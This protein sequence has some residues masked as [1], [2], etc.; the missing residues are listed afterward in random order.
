MAPPSRKFQPKSIRNPS[1]KDAIS[2]GN[3]RS[4]TLQS[5]KLPLQLEDDVPDFPRGGR[6]SFRKEEKDKIG[7][8]LDNDI[9]ADHRSLEKRKKGK[10]VQKKNQSEEDDL[11][12]LFG[13]GIKGK[14]PRYSNRIT[15]KNV[16]P[17]MKLWGVIAEV[18]EKDIVVSLPGGLRG[19]IRACEAF[20]PILGGEV[21]QDAQ[22]NFLSSVYAGQLVSCIVMQ[23][24][25]DKKEVVNRKIWLSLHLS[26][27]HKGL[28]LDIIQEGMV[29]SAYVKSIEDHGF[30]LHF[31]C[32][33][34]TGFMSKHSKSEKGSSEVRVGQILQGVVRSVDRARKVVHIDS[35]PDVVSKYVTKELK[36]VSLDLLIPGMMVDARVVSTL[37]NGIMLSFLTYFTGT[38]DVFNLDKTFPSP[39]WKDDYSKNMRINARILFIDP[40]TRAVGLT[41]NPYLVGNNA[42]PS[43]VK[44][45]DIFDQ[46]KVIRVD[47][48]S[49]LLL[50]TPTLP[51]PTPTYVN[52]TDVAD[53]DV[54]K[55]EKSFKEGSLVR[56]RVLGFRRLEGLATGILKTSAFEGSVFT[57]SDVKPGMVVKAK[58]IAV[59]SF[60]AIVQISSGVKALCPLRHMSEL[61]IQK[62]RK[63][64]QV[65]VE[66]VFRVL[67]CKSKRITVTHKKTLVKSK[68][69]ILSSY[70]DATNGLVTHGW[71]TKIENHG[72]FVRFYNGVQGF[73]PRYELCLDPGSDIDSMYHVEQVVKCR[74]V[75]CIPAS[76]RM[77]LSFN[78]SLTRAV[79]VESV[80][81]GSLVA[82]VVEK[83]S[84]HE[85]VVDVNASSHMKGTISLEHLAD[86]HGLAI[87]MVSA[88]KPGYQ[89]D[90]LLVLDIEGNNLVLT[91]KYSLINSAQELPVDVTQIRCHST[92]PGY[93][94]NIIESGCFV[95][96]IGHLTGFA[97]K[98]KATD[99]WRTD[100]S[101]VFFV[102]QSVRSNI[103][104]VGSE[105]GRI[106]LS[107]KQ[108]LCCSTDSSFIQEY[109]LMEE[110]IA[111]LQL[112]DSEGLALSWISAFDIGSI[113][114]GKV[115]ETKD[116]GVIISFKKYND[117]Y[118]FI[119]H[120][121]L[122]GIT[123]ENNSTVRALVID[124]SKIERLV[125]L[126]LKPEFLKSPKE[127]SSISKTVKKRKSREYNKLELNQV[128]DALVEIVKETYL[129][130]SIPSHNFAIGY[131]SITDYNN[132]KLPPKQYTNG[133]SVTA[134]VVALPNPT[135]CGRLLLLLKTL[136]DGTES[137]SSKRAK[138]KSSYD[139][140]SLVQVEITE[141]KPLELR[142]KFG[143]GFHGRI[144]VTEAADNNSSENPFSDYRIGQTLLARIVSK[145]SMPYSSKGSYPW[146]FSIKPSILKGSSDM[147]GLIPAEDFNYSCGQYVSGYVYKIDH[148]WAWLTVSRKVKARLHILD[149]SCEPSELAKFRERFFV[150]K[151]LSG[152][153]ISINEEKKLLHV[154]LSPLAVGFGEL[155]ENDPYCH[156]KFHIIE[157]T[158]VGGRISKVIPG[159][160]GLLVQIDQHLYGKVH[161]T[162]LTDAWVS[163]PLSGYREGQFVKCKVLEINRTGNGTFHIDLSLR[164]TSN[165]RR[166][167][168]LTEHSSGMPSS[169][170]HVDKL[171]DLRP[172]MVVQG[173]VKNISAK[174]CFV[175]LSRKIDA[176]V[177]L[178]NLSVN[179]VDNPEKDF[180][181]GKLVSGRVLSVEP[182]SNRVEL[183]LKTPIATSGPKSDAYSLNNI[184]VGDIISGRIKR[185]ESYG[186]FISIDQTNVVGLCHV[187]EL[188]DIHLVNIETKFNVAERV[189]AKVLKVDEERNRVSLGM[190]KSYFKDEETLK[191][192]SRQSLD[193]DV[194]KNS[195]MVEAVSKT[196]LQSSSAS[197]EN[198]NLEVESGYHSIL[199]D[200]ENRALVPPLEVPLDDLEMTDNEVDVD[201]VPNAADA[202]IIEEKNRRAKKKARE[203]RE[204]EIRAA[205]ERLLEKDIPKSTDEFEKLV[206]SSPNSSF[207]W[208]KYMAFML[209]LADVEK[210]RSIAERALRTINIREESEKLNIWVAYFNLEN[211]YG[212]PPE[213][214]VMKIF[215]RALQYC[216]PKKVHIALLRM[217]QRTEQ[218]KLA[219]EHLD[220][221][222]R[223]FKHS[224]K[225]WLSRIQSLLKQNSDGIQSVV[226]RALLRLPRHKHIKF[227]SQTAILEFKCGVPDR[228]RSLFEGMLREYPKRTDLWSIYLDQE[229]RLG[230][231][232]VVRALFER[233]ISLC[234]PPKKMKFLFKK[235]LEYEKSIG[236]E[237][238]IES[239]K[240]KALD[241]AESTLA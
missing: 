226:N 159:V 204:Q 66:L 46:S 36:G 139:V 168:S 182:L 131:A 41:L 237:E 30:I 81:P 235:Y 75:K 65:G 118:G 3:R 124:V 86:H 18:N 189:T 229:I 88:L 157:G 79:G 87:L 14:M 15:L 206:R 129:V 150:G 2:K 236:E 199:A 16:S 166:D 171:T 97:P 48:G 125:D 13:D 117:V 155:N 134:T 63:K 104:D 224:C 17:G 11:G 62:P 123:V 119:S 222:A 9:E 135:T 99:Q 64:F 112:L 110:K 191:M 106:T 91:A 121:Q 143:S 154:V 55:L 200:F 108:S 44:I 133:Q 22:K 47:K 98:S 239:V 193:D 233:A 114:E 144:H 26:L 20:D 196:L 164:S 58:V 201:H 151:A 214:A 232:D 228:G 153:I 146:E 116:F 92:V 53:K 39:K 68:L 176:K 52:V 38:A 72:C 152:Y 142:L 137:S 107:L 148:Q 23:V 120:Y 54:Q 225:V 24:D 174:G 89:F 178:S 234:L 7:T 27:L 61:E 71:I 209:S 179:F 210:A 57:H 190:K 217:Y 212:N 187:S 43:L 49:G 45:G 34:F 10:K 240:K 185:V 223:K 231:G 25:D 101:E 5:Q 103:V 93:V 161:F 183:T 28:T 111:K 172:N 170:Q 35:N 207:I 194:E 85:I 4:R 216:D 8:I 177:L 33:Y 149:S 1:R 156:P 77:H 215:Q 56:V 127:D 82:G 181:V 74:V 198:S 51:V 165:D 141:R 31:G 94:C 221:M 211:E 175:M 192:I 205:E 220:R 69:E 126:T 184:I 169:T 202:D 167:L 158:Y 80:K 213:D 113:V 19:L 59:D 70:A 29:L 195:S 130:L 188:S 219:S 100:L 67:G 105:T 160:G 138:N 173:Y 102:G 238:R 241:Y 12:S 145:G 42:P 90:Q 140:G 230:D 76:R 136:S 73:A 203:E 132:Q 95:R 208:I 83:V 50:E 84:S 186:L 37:E 162:E 122:A 60:G 180:P 163:D 128:V 227:I 78:M 96:F 197:I 218:H 40:S 21:E 109:F 32:P 147:D 115:H 6:K